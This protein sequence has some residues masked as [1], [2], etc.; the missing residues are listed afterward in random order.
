MMH[1]GSASHGA[2]KILLHYPVLNTGGAE[3]ST[4]RLM[5]AL[6]ERGCE[7]HLV[8]TVGGGSLEPRIDPRVAVHHLRD[9]IGDLSTRVTGF[10]DAIRF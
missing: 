6:V 9:G 3:H 10:A 7:V 5:S 2:L 1:A 8:L 4:L